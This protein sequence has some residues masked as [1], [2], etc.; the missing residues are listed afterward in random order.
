MKPVFLTLLLLNSLFSFSQN[1]PKD[2]NVISVRGVKF[3]DVCNALLDSGYTIEKKDND[4]QTAQTGIKEYPRYWNA[5]Y[6]FHV[7]VK[8]SILYLSATFTAPPHGELFS[9]EPA[10]NR[11]NKKGKVL[12]KS[13]DGYIFLLLNG[14]A[15]SF[16]KEVAY[17]K[18]K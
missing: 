10:G 16:N 11:L 9:N 2:V 14:F 7:R 15:L 8:D 5:T 13:M 6:V 17:T 3:I 1:I 12:Y 4:L 18:S